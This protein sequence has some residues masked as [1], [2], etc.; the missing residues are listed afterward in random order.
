[1]KR[2]PPFLLA[3][4]TSLILF[5][6][7]NAPVGAVC[8]GGTWRGYQRLPESCEDSAGDPCSRGDDDC[9]CTGGYCDSRYTQAEERCSD[10]SDAACTTPAWECDNGVSCSVVPTTPPQPTPT[11]TPTP[12]GPTYTPTPTPRG[13]TPVPTRAPTP[14]S[15]PAT[16]TPTSGFRGACAPL[17]SDGSCGTAKVPG[18]LGVGGCYSTPRV[19]RS[20]IALL[21]PLD[22]S[23]PNTSQW[24]DAGTID[25]GCSAN[26]SEE[27]PRSGN[28]RLRV[29][30][31]TNNGNREGLCVRDGQI[32]YDDG[33]IR[34]GGVNNGNSSCYFL[35]SDLNGLSTGLTVV[36]YPQCAGYNDSNAVGCTYG[37]T[38]VKKDIS[39]RVIDRSASTGGL[40][41]GAD[42]AKVRVSRLWPA[43]WPANKDSVVEFIEVNTD[44]EG[45]YTVK[46]W[47]FTGE[48]YKVEVITS[49]TEYVNPSVV[50]WNNVGA[51][52][53]TT[54]SNTKQSLDP[55]PSPN[56]SVGATSYNYQK[57]G[58][59]DCTNSQGS[60]PAN[61]CWFA[62]DNN[63]LTI[64]G[65]VVIENIKTNNANF[66]PVA[67]I[68]YPVNVHY[69]GT[70]MTTYTD[71]NGNFSLPNYVQKGTAYYVTAYNPQNGQYPTGYDSSRIISWAHNNCAGPDSAGLID[72]CLIY[73]H[74]V[75]PTATI[76]A[77]CAPSYGLT[78][79]NTSRAFTLT[80]TNG[81]GNT[82]TSV[83]GTNVSQI[84]AWT[85]SMFSKSISGTNTPFPL[86][87]TVSGSPVTQL[88]PNVNYFFRYGNGRGHL[89]D[90]VNRSVPECGYTM[91]NAYLDGQPLTRYTVAGLL[92]QYTNNVPFASFT[93]DNRD[94]TYYDINNPGAITNWK[95][96]I[97]ARQNPYSGTTFGATVRIDETLPI[98]LDTSRANP[99]QASPGGGSAL[100]GQADSSNGDLMYGY[101]WPYWSSNSPG[102]AARYVNIYLRTK[103]PTCN[104]SLSPDPTT[105]DMG[106]SQNFVPSITNPQNGTVV[107]TQYQITGPVNSVGTN[108]SSPYNLTFSN[109]TVPGTYTMR[110]NV[111]MRQS[112]TNAVSTACTDT[113]TIT[114]PVPSCNVGLSMSSSTVQ[115][116]NPNTNPAVT[117]PMSSLVTVGVSSIVGG[118]VSRVDFSQI[119]TTKLDLNPTSDN[120]NPYQTTATANGSGTGDQQ[121]KADVYFGNVPSSYN[122]VCTITTNG[123]VAGGTGN[124]PPICVSQ[125][126]PTYQCGQHDLCG[127][128]CNN[129]DALAP[130]VP[131]YTISSKDGGALSGS[132][133]EMGSTGDIVYITIT[134]PRAASN[135]PMTNYDL[136][137]YKKN[138]FATADAAFAQCGSSTQV[139][140]AVN[141]AFTSPSLRYDYTPTA[142]INYETVVA[143]RAYNR[144]CTGLFDRNGNPITFLVSNWNSNNVDLVADINNPVEIRNDTTQCNSGSGTAI[145]SMAGLSA[146]LTDNGSITRN[147][148][149]DESNKRL[150]FDNLPFR[151]NGSWGSGYRITLTINNTVPGRTGG[152]EVYCGCTG[153]IGSESCIGKTAANDSIHYNP[154]NTTFKLMEIPTNLGSW[155]QVIN[156]N[157]YSMNTMNSQ[158]PQYDNSSSSNFVGQIV[159]AFDK[160]VSGL[161]ITS[162]DIKNANTQGVPVS[163][164]QISTNSSGNNSWM[165]EVDPQQFVGSGSRHADTLKTNYEYYIKKVDLATQGTQIN[166]STVD[167]LPNNDPVDADEDNLEIYY[168]TGDLTLD[169][170]TN[171]K[172]QITGGRKVV[173]FVNGNVM[174]DDFDSIQ[175]LI[176]VETGSFFGIIS[177]G[178]ITFNARVGYQHFDLA[179]AQPMVTIF[180]INTQPTYTGSDNQT[181]ANVEGVFVADQ[182]VF[183]TFGN[184]Q[185][186]KKFIGAG[187]FF[188]VNN[189][190]LRRKYY[191]NNTAILSPAILS[192]RMNN[193]SP[194]EVFIYRPD[195]VINFPEPLMDANTLWQEVNG[196]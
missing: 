126:V 155:W 131:A 63:Y 188:A 96:E 17:E 83:D 109:P 140:C 124:P 177:S 118:T 167:A 186:D 35:G 24:V 174:I 37:K 10:Y 181:N 82:Y 88:F 38:I 2:L 19:I 111:Q 79:P 93:N 36:T 172:W 70:F 144:H 62:V 72:E 75:E 187:T 43:G 58:S 122:P 45:Y 32:T 40:I 133:L 193:Y 29:D 159:G 91:F 90:P 95:V 78:I 196:P 116:P 76:D 59:S 154:I 5:L 171:G 39:G 125:C 175:Q 135:G 173:F 27:D 49:G 33:D 152:S 73:V 66:T 112:L 157:A 130:A 145:S 51:V 156:G 14:T 87:F 34:R 85:H 65:R 106:G 138:A 46:N 182:L 74:A 4:L 192:Q 50:A 121:I 67:A 139:H 60:D 68:G 77:Y 48:Y 127:N 61:R 13:A 153:P 110:V 81:V 8:G 183:D 86:G 165:R 69:N 15:A 44:S 20:N 137:V 108:N 101:Q 103:P 191:F 161:S 190:E 142:A 146:V 148:V 12:I 41:I 47:L 25:F 94:N 26:W 84:G 136:V 176:S 102:G 16:P 31:Y 57:M 98:E 97:P 80:W 120:S 7:A 113:A 166:T 178:T 132:Q 143:V 141:Q 22:D 158:I 53:G 1:M 194:T 30:Y 115:G 163:N 42:N 18:A 89:Y 169:I 55:N 184:A 195:F 117:Y 160:L 164:L 128:N 119:T 100:T 168:R 3:L 28:E 23:D 149:V 104:V 105:V 147:G 52:A 114:V 170:P 134:D 123:S 179:S 185:A 9:T 21:D 129:A 162:I 107:G 151:P 54:I 180:G 64:S 189:I 11:R 92:Y 150:V 56:T 99:V 6:A 71:N